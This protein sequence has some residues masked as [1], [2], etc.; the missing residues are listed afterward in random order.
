MA[1]LLQRI[2]QIAPVPVVALF[3][4][5]AETPRF[6]PDDPLPAMPAP[7]PVGE[8]RSVRI[9]ALYDFLLQSGR[10]SRRPPAPALGINTLGEAPDSSWYTNR[11]ATRRMTRDE[12]QRGPG[13]DKAPAPPLVIVG[14]KTDGITPGFRMKDSEGRL[15]FVKPDPPSNPEMST[16]AEMIGSRFFHALGYN[17]PE[18]YLIRVHPSALA[19]DSQATV[20]GASGR[21]RPMDRRDLDEVFRNVARDRSGKV[22][23]VASLAL[24]GR[25]IGP[26]KYEGTRSD[27]P[28]DT[29]PHERRRD[30]RG[31]Y[32]FCAWLNHT[33][34][35]AQNTLDT[36][37]RQDGVRFIRHHLID[38]GA[39]LGS[40]SDMPKPARTGNAYV[41]PTGRETLLRLATFGLHSKPWERAEYSGMRAVGRFEAEVFDPETWRP[42]YPNPAF[43]SRQA[44]DEYWAAKQV[45]SFTDED[46]R[47]IVETGE[48]S[49]PRVVEYIVKTLA[50]RRDKIGRAY[51]TRMLA[52]DSFRVEQGELRFEDLAVA[53]GLSKPASYRVTWSQFD[54]RA[55]QH[56]PAQGDSFSLPQEWHSAPAGSYFSARIGSDAPDERQVV[57]FLRK[58]ATGGQVV[59]I[60]RHSA[61][62]EMRSA[63]CCNC[64][65]AAGGRC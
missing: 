15:Y 26:F 24:E 34:T 56:T 36:I 64:G 46:I 32:V 23:M 54:N 1:T 25:P 45:M 58:K 31:L 63:Q 20:S 7:L 65:R 16:A 41:L 8:I 2:R 57:V 11:H 33:D 40:A 61:D 37:V 5:Q 38:F 9:E 51:L 6:F 28:N 30:L 42:N 62:S 12:L 4:A 52:L 18:N 13:N 29:I 17:T 49:D 43:L 53:H 14:A 48:Y 50:A 3:L 21:P 10:P 44:D 59:G 19:I 35:K 47:A 39:I 60:E 22:R 27:D 55:R